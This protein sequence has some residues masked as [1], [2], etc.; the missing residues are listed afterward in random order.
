MQV[1]F[2]VLEESRRPQGS[3]STN[4]QVLVFVIVLKSNV[5]ILF[6]VLRPSVLFLVLILE[7]QKT[8]NFARTLQTF[9]GAHCATDCQLHLMCLSAHLYQPD[10]Y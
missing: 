7:L 4:F 10:L 1:I 9:C 5:F 6:L 8:H 2:V 3:L